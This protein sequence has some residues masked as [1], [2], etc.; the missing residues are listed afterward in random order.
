MTSRITDL[1]DPAFHKLFTDVRQSW[2]R[3]ETLQRYDVPYERDEFAAWMRG[4]AV[5]KTPGPWQAMIRAHV[6]A[7]RHLS[8][9]HII[10]EPLSDYLR[11]ELAGYPVNIEAGE[12]V[13]VI[14][15]QHG[16]WPAGVPRHDFWL[17]DD[18]DLWLM[19]Y[20]DAGR[21]VAAELVTDPDEIAQ[22]RTWRDSALAQAVPVATYTAASRR[23][24]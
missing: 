20:D 4:E 23:A 1:A 19:K 3:L 14:P 2:F 7:G 22:H 24:S 16:R 10:E 12:D 13:R 17:F 6:A 5:D 18:R 11:F 9:V 8:R 21:F 15:V